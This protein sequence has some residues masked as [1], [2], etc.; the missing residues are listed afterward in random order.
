MKVMNR[1]ALFEQSERHPLLDNHPLKFEW[2]GYR[3]ISITGDLRLI[4]KKYPADLV[5][6][7]AVGT[8]GEL[9]G[10]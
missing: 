8:N 1:L 4:F 3:S 2:E 7:E 6:L 10:K 9:Y 5:R